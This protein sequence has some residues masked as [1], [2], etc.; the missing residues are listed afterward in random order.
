[1]K[2]DGL[3]TPRADWVRILEAA[4]DPVAD[5]RTWAKGVVDAMSRIFRRS[6]A[7]VLHLL[8]HDPECVDVRLLANLGSGAVGDRI[9]KYVGSTPPSAL[10]PLGFRGFFYPPVMVTTHS[11]IDPS[12]GP[13]L[14]ELMLEYRRSQ[15]IVDMA[16]IVVHPLPGFALV[17]AC[18]LDR[19]TTPSPYERAVLS[20]VGLHL[21]SAYRLRRR[22]ETV[23]GVLTLKGRKSEGASL[24]EQARQI[25]F[26]MTRKGRA[27]HEGALA[28]WTALVGGRY[29]LV[30]RDGSYLVLENSPFS[31]QMRAL[32]PR[33][34]DVLS[35][36]AR[37]LST[38][39]VSYGLGLSSGTVSSA[40]ARAA[41]K[42]GLA[43]RLELLRLA[44]TITHDPRSHAKPATLTAAESEV[45]A[46]LRQGMSNEQIA[47][48]RS[49]SVRTVVNQVASLLRK[50]KSES[51]RALVADTSLAAVVTGAATTKPRREK[52]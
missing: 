12:L 51:R 23:K 45:L 8:E 46:L 26:S 21:E 1:M 30:A 38:K 14:P 18:A 19:L 9:A 29:S 11:E 35:M 47:R 27:Q 20:R 44:A 16:G 43:S 15:G 31:Q 7:T 50:T 25:D 3:L 24:A 42:L 22:P 39:L 36:S 17:V 5:D 49:R 28:L 4:Y 6:D 52:K 13:D 41:S 2:K 48:T 10:G 34:I 37:G 33:E 32:T 40:L